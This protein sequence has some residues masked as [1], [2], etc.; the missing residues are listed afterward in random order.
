MTIFEL[1]KKAVDP[2]KQPYTASTIKR[3]LNFHE[4]RARFALKLIENDRELFDIVSNYYWKHRNPSTIRSA[5]TRFYQGKGRY[6]QQILELLTRDNIRK[7]ETIGTLLGYLSKELVESPSEVVNIVF[8]EVQKNHTHDI[9]KEHIETVLSS[10]KLERHPT[11]DK[12]L[13]ARCMYLY[14][15]C[16]GVEVDGEVVVGDIFDILHTLHVSYKLIGVD[17]YV[18]GGFKSVIDE[19]HTNQKAVWLAGQSFNTGVSE[20]GWIEAGFSVHDGTADGGMRYEIR[21]GQYMDRDLEEYE[22]GEDRVWTLL[23][24][25]GMGLFE[26]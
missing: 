25:S 19:P 20:E 9:V 3:F 8:E 2:A 1:I 22:S 5:K 4:R 12:Y 7:Q 15:L 23:A 6:G 11:K 10:T 24:I 26:G 14:S 21:L 13:I 17:G 16:Y 18:W